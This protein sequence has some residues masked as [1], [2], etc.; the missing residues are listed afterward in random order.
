MADMF[1][2]DQVAAYNISILSLRRAALTLTQIRGRFPDLV[3]LH[4]A[5][6]P[7]LHDREP[8]SRRY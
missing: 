7:F 3:S 6:E 4:V 8:T 5:L 2:Q 1:E